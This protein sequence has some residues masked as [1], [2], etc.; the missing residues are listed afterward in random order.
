[1]TDNFD[2]LSKD[3]PVFRELRNLMDM[4]VVAAIIKKDNLVEQLDMNLPG[5]LGQE[6][7]STPSW[8]IPQQVPTQCSFVKLTKSW[9]VTASG[10]V[11]VDSFAVAEKTE[12]VASLGEIAAIASQRSA[13]NWWWNAN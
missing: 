13:D 2:Q 8:N 10:G 7:I 11:D 9:L 3:Q 4:S 1:M 12:K 5:I 6:L